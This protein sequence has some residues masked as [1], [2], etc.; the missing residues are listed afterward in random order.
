V[1][2]PRVSVKLELFHAVQRITW[3]LPKGYPLIGPCTKKLNLVFRKDGDTGEK[4]KQALVLV[5]MFSMVLV[6]LVVV[7]F[8]MA[9]VVLVFFF[10]GFGD[11]VVV[12][13]SIVLVVLVVLVVLKVLV[14]MM[15]L[16][17]WCF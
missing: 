10:H 1:F 9:L 2:G 11:L 14:F 15:V 4:R 5:L 13:V 17:G 7:M 6:I 8:S 3:T 12:M 16:V